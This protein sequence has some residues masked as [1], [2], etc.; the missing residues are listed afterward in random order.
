MTRCFEAA[1]CVAVLLLLDAQPSWAQGS[2]GGGTL[3]IR[4]ADAEQGPLENVAPTPTSRQATAAREAEQLRPPISTGAQFEPGYYRG[5]VP[6]EN[7]VPPRARWLKRTRRNFV[8]WPGF[9]MTSSGSR[10]FVQTTHP[11]TYERADEPNRIVLILH[12]TRIHLRN[13]RN[14]LV[15]EHFNTPVARAYLRYRRGNTLLVLDMKVESSPSIRQM[16]EGNYHFV[17]LEFPPG[18][19]PI[20]EGVREWHGGLTVSGSD[21]SPSYKSPVKPL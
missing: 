17:M 12:D 2:E 6:G 13:N 5:V 19:Y 7:H 16:S 1:L 15:T 3:V 11:V 4:P 10:I 21:M 14:P 18:N 8:T 9:E 20:P